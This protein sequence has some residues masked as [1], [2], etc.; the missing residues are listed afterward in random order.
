MSNASFL[1]TARV[2]I[3][4]K[5]EQ[6]KSFASINDLKSLIP[7]SLSANKSLIPFAGNLVSINLANKNGHLISTETALAH[8]KLF[9]HA[10][11]D[12]EHSFIDKVC[13][14]IVSVH[15]TEFDP[16]YELGHGSKILTEDDVRGKNT[17]FNIS[18]V[19]VLYE[20]SVSGA[21][22]KIISSCDAESEDYL[23]V[24][25]S[26]ELGF[27]ESNILLGHSM[28]N[29]KVIE[30]ATEKL[31]YTKYL[32]GN[33]GSG[34]LK[35]GTPVNLLITGSVTPLGVG[36]TLSPASSVKGIVIPD[37]VIAAKTQDNEEVEASLE[38]EI[39]AKDT[40]LTIID[41]IIDISENKNSHLE[42]PAVTPIRHKDNALDKELITASSPQSK[43]L[44]KTM[45]LLQSFAEIQ[46]LND[47]SV[48]EVSLANLK[49]LLEAKIKEVSEKWQ[50]D[51][52]EK[53]QAVKASEE[54][55]ALA[56]AAALQAK[57]E[58][59]VL[60]KKIA[61]LELSQ[62]NAEAEAKF[63][64][65]MTAFDE[66]YEL[67][68]EDSTVVASSIKDISDAAFEKFSKDFSILA[69]HKDKEFIQEQLI[70]ANAEK[71]KGNK[72]SKVVIASVLD[73]A[74]VEPAVVPNSPSAAE[75]LKGKYKD[76]F[77]GVVG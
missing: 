49:P 19:G 21:L 66:K 18:I 2:L 69:K 70:K 77:A 43:T 44:P 64:A 30:E 40:D 37:N 76:A 50:K 67:S 5:D 62:A 14:H 27:S 25:L 29:G 71:N 10:R 57:E 11:A 3:K 20:D 65:R 6:L 63:Q 32:K 46:E 26:W 42:I 38:L 60:S 4:D 9:E 34:S 59:E 47:E 51:N 74:V 52:E 24:S 58:T 48:K 13:G 7:E 53:A 72:D 8:Y 17:P 22:D 35:D 23:S 15:L 1:S 73:N 75:S 31:K 54:K 41:K 39:A 33:S 36:L 45:K 56:E 68:E 16:E 61:A 28:E 12:L 55:T